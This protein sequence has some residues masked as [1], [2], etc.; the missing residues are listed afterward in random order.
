MRQ[1]IHYYYPS[2]PKRIVA[3]AQK[4]KYKPDQFLDYFC[5]FKGLQKVAGIRLKP[6]ARNKALLFISYNVYGVYL[7]SGLFTTFSNFAV[8]AIC[9][10][11]LPFIV[12]GMV[13]A[14]LYMTG[15]VQKTGRNLGGSAKRKK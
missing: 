2:M 7:L 9:L 6:T 14:V 13:Y 8:G 4:E 3:M 12:T 5:K 1:F 15:I 10:A 11:L